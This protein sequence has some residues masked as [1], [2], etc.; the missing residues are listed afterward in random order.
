MPRHDDGLPPTVWAQVANTLL[1]EALT[2]DGVCVPVE[3][4]C[5]WADVLGATAADVSRVAGP[6]GM[7]ARDADR[8]PMRH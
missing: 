8:P 6:T 4:A 3:E 5:R 7:P 2:G 1:G